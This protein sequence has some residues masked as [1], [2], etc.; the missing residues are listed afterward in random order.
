M[1]IQDLYHLYFC[2]VWDIHLQM[3]CLLFY[4]NKYL[5]IKYPFSYLIYTLKGQGL[6]I[7]TGWKYNGLIG[8]V[9]EMVRQLFI[10]FKTVSLELFWSKK[11]LA[12]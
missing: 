2:A 3:F 10:I 7:I 12:A 4:I 11:F 6:D 1:S 9:Y 5:Y 8:L